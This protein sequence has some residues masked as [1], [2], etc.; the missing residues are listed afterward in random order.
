MIRL[1]A[2]RTSGIKLRNE[3]IGG[4][5]D[6]KKKTPIVKIKTKNEKSDRW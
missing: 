6:V 5:L 4:K 1:S 3:E 2:K